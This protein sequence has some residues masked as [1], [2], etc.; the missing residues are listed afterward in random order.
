MTEVSSVFDDVAAECE[1]K[2]ERNFSFRVWICDIT[3]TLQH[4]WSYALK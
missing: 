3:V 4:S 2:R 1:G